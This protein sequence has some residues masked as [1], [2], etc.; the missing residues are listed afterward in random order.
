MAASH[1]KTVT[2]SSK[3]WVVIP[4]PLRRK[5][6]LRPGMKMHV[7][8]IEGRIIL[9]PQREDPVDAL[10]GCLAG[11]ESLTG[12]LLEEKR[13]EKAHDESKFRSG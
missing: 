13:R 4:S 12:V 5:I 10:F 6:D 7:E 8:E 3:G 9:T 11:E 2:V 1:R